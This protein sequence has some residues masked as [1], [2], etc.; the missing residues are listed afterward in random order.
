MIW[1]KV[2]TKILSGCAAATLFLLL[3]SPNGYAQGWQNYGVRSGQSIGLGGGQ[4]LAP[5]AGGQSVLVAAYLS[6]HAF[7]ARRSESLG[8]HD[9]D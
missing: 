2:V 8:K 1:G 5:V 7:E 3:A 9:P 6:S 4:S